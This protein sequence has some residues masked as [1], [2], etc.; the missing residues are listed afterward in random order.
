MCADM[1]CKDDVTQYLVAFGDM[2][3]IVYLYV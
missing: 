3:F 2:N 1:Y